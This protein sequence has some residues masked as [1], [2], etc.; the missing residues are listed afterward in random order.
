[1]ISA[2]I[3][4]ARGDALVTRGPSGSVSGPNLDKSKNFSVLA[5]EINFVATVVWVAP[6][7]SN[8]IKTLA[9]K[10]TAG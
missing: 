8:N 9:E 1:M 7:L 6:V 2:E 3:F 5:D 10:K 4:F